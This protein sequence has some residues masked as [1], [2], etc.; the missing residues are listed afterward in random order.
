MSSTHATSR[1]AASDLSCR[2][3]AKEQRIGRVGSSQEEARSLCPGFIYHRRKLWFWLCDNFRGGNADGKT[4][5]TAG[6]RQEHPLPRPPNIRPAEVTL[7]LYEVKRTSIPCAE[8]RDSAAL[9]GRGRALE[10]TR[11][12][13]A[14]SNTYGTSDG[15]EISALPSGALHLT[16][17]EPTTT[18]YDKGCEICNVHARNIWHCNVCKFLYC[19]GC[20]NDQPLHRRPARKGHGDIPHEKTDPTIAEKVKAVMFPPVDERTREQLYRADEITSW[21]GTFAP[22]PDVE[23]VAVDNN[24]RRCRKA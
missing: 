1:T 17:E 5:R 13:Q 3:P 7:P 23:T 18:N 2:S 12:S 4:H 10:S 11:P 6:R 15:P 9:H 14:A 8:F 21:F 22:A 16:T 19:D 24:S 20:W